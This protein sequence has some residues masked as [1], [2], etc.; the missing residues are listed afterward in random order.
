[1][2]GDDDQR[3]RGL[4]RGR[5]C[6]VRP[7][8]VS[9]RPAS[10][11]GLP[12]TPQGRP[13]VIQRLNHVVCALLLCTGGVVGAQ[14]PAGAPRDTAPPAPA[15]A[16]LVGKVVDSTGAG[17][18]GA[19]ITMLKSDKV[20]SISSDSGTFKISGIPAGAV[21]FSVRRIGYE[22]ATFTAVLK[23]GK[24]S[25]ANFSLTATAHELATVEVKDTA[26]QSHWLDA[27]KERKGNGRGTFITH[28][29]LVRRGV[30][31]GIDAIRSIPGIRIVAQR[32]GQANRV[33]MTRTTTRSCSPTMYLH[34]LPYSGS[35]DDFL[36]EDIEAIEVYVGESEIPPEF[37]RNS[38][39][40]CGVINVWTRDPRKSP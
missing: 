39:G 11:V 3:Y 34:G 22:S 5:Y 4:E 21:T 30:R 1:M 27:F 7:S 10:L 8:T 29:Q 18:G 38:R 9:F 16:T 13:M 32:G 31:T 12:P 17:L 14:V 36:T 2:S 25:R 6:T 33:I 20:Y 23:A 35:M 19:E 28:D 37:D 40:V 24:T 15:P 26:S